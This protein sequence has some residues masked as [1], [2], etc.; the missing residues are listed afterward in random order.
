M[1]C[2]MWMKSFSITS[3][4]MVHAKETIVPYVDRLFEELPEGVEI[5]HIWSDGPSSQFKNRFMTVAQVVLQEKYKIKLYWNFFPTSHGKGAV[6]GIGGALKRQVWFNVK[7]RIS[8]VSNASEFTEAVNENSKV[9]EIYMNS[10]EISE[11]F[12]SL[13]LDDQW[14]KVPDVRGILNFHHIQIHNGKVHGFLTTLEG[15]NSL[16]IIE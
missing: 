6:D 9:K 1:W 5:V 3:D 7:S 15:M 11:R 16:N 4:D 13:K 2:S 14:K 8:T 12:T 10:N